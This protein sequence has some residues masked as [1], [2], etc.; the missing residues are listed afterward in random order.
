MNKELEKKLSD[1]FSFMKKG[2]TLAEQYNAG[3]IVERYTNFKKPHCK[4][5]MEE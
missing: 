5:I 3:F 1:R 2:K 4:E